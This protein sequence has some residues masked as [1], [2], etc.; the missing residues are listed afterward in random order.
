MWEGLEASRRSQSLA[1]GAAA[2]VGS[3]EQEGDSA[4]ESSGVKRV[5]ARSWAR[6]RQALQGFPG[7]LLSEWEA[8]AGA[9]ELPG[10]RGAQ[11]S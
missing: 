6:G 1:R 2:V 8:G 11:R 7:E 10:V 9:G 5:A 4:G 3:S